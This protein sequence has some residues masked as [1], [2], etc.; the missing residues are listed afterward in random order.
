M[1][2]I[3]DENIPFVKNAFERLG[4]ITTISGRQITR[5]I[6]LDADVLLVRSITKVDK[7]LLNGTSV[8]FVATATIGT[9]HVDLDYLNSH[10]IGFSDA[11][12]SNA[13]SVA[14]YVMTALLHFANQNGIQLEGKVLGVVGVGN[15]GSKVV[16]MA[17]G[18]GMTVLQ[19]D[20]P[21]ARLTAEPRFMPLDDLMDADFITLHVP[22]T[23]KGQDVTFHLFDAGRISKMK[24]GS[25]LINSSRGSVVDNIALIH[26]L[27]SGHLSTAILDVWENEPDINIELLKLVYLGTPHIAGYSLDGKINGT[28]MIYE[29]TCRYFNIYPD[30]D[31]TQLMPAPQVAMIQCQ[32]SREN[33]ESILHRVVQQVY[34][35]ARDARSLK[36]IIH[37]QKDDRDSYFDKL[38]K[39]YPI[40]REFHNTK[41]QF[42]DRS[43]KLKHKITAL[44][45]QINERKTEVN[46]PRNRKGY[47][48]GR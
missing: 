2:I 25:I 31:F 23:R 21:L 35:I 22:L 1:K 12:G 4:V 32:S 33:D 18:L 16:R 5:Q 13:N 27:K 6:L 38:R 47:A 24:P 45:F 28:R 40:R 17:E 15:I 30:L 39:E 7:Q 10:G 44:G 46:R 41:I 14:E 3:A 37:V 9:E 19:N 11:A 36:K 29:A 26:L 20:P 34:P 43:D 48:L 8:K 42:Q